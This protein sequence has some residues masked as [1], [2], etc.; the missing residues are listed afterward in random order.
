METNIK[1]ESSSQPYFQ[2]DQ[3]GDQKTEYVS[4]RSSIDSS[5]VFPLNNVYD[6]QGKILPHAYPLVKP[7]A[8]QADLTWGR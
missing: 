7:G 8:K 6:S 3:A 4:K 5:T 2:E 1:P